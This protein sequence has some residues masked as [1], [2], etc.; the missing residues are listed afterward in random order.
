MVRGRRGWRRPV[1]GGVDRD[2]GFGGFLG[3]S[4]DTAHTL[5]NFPPIELTW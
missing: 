1:V 3:R 4:G 2:T 5:V